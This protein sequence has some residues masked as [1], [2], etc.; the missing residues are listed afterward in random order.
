ME[1]ALEFPRSFAALGEEWRA[2]EV[3]ADRPE[4]FRSWTWVGC[5][6]EERFP[7]PVLL[8]ATRAGRTV[9]LALCNRRRGRFSGR[10]YLGESGNPVLDAPF[11]EHN[12]PLLARG[13][14]AETWTAMLGVLLQAPGA[15][16]LVLS[17]VHPGLADTARAEGGAVLPFQL[18]DA[19]VVRLDEIRAAGTGY[20]GTRSANTRYQI[21]R[22]LKRYAGAGALA[23]ERAATVAEAHAWLDALMD[24]HGATWRARGEPGAFAHPFMLRFHRALIERAQPRGEVDLLRASAGGTPFGYLYN[25]RRDGC[26]YTYQSGLDYAAFGPHTKPGLTC[27]YLA[28]E[29]AL[30]LGDHTYDFLAGTDRYKRSLA[31]AAVP[32]LWAEVVPRR[33]LAALVVRARDLSMRLRG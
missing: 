12:G 3:K 29:R 27:H 14:E 8:R 13:E 18:R 6:A 23:L 11:V 19:P 17:G 10:L 25:L 30:G 16:R 5:L 1:V 4:L 20:L 22:S 32:L 7:D 26:V 28:I 31:N 15:G 24:L 21:R 9:G 2:L 33:S